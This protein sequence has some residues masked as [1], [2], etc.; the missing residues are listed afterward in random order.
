MLIE[1]DES[2]APLVPEIGIDVIINS[3]FN[4][5]MGRVEAIDQ[6][7]ILTIDVVRTRG[8]GS[9]LLTGRIGSFTSGNPG[10]AFVARKKAIQRAIW[11]KQSTW[12]KTLLLSHENHSIQLTNP[13]VPFLGAWAGSLPT[14]HNNQAQAF[15]RAVYEGATLSHIVTMVKGHTG[16]GKAGLNGSC[17]VNCTTRQNDWL[18]VAET[19]LAIQVC[20]DRIQPYLIQ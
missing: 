18:L 11:S 16:T 2:D 1:A 7:S 10:A 15:A 5:L 4:Q 19:H 13:L 9:L 17:V 6:D 8:V 3:S 12:L 20:A 14:L